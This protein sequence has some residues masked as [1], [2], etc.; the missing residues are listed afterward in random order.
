MRKSE[1]M[2][3]DQA[4][5]AARQVFLR[6]GYKRTTMGDIAAEAHMSRPALYLLFPSK[7][8]VFGAVMERLFAE[9]LATIRGGIS[10]RTTAHKQL[11][12]AFDVWAVQ[13]FKAVQAAPDAKDMLESS[14]AFAHA[15]T[16]KAAADF[17]HILVSVLQPLATRAPVTTS[18]ERAA[19]LLVAAIPGFK[20]SAP[21][22]K[23]LQ[24][25]IEDLVTVVLASEHETTS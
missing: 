5:A 8:D 24:Q 7:E 16:A 15:I 18:P 20:Q 14:Y 9:M 10:K 4:L 1:A 23:Q 21:S 22:V 6:Y 19:H 13:P 25:L 11:L 2:R 3:R 17:E 12:F